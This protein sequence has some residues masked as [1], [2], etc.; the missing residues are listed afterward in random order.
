M[1]KFGAQ[2]RATSLAQKN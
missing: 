1:H 2:Y